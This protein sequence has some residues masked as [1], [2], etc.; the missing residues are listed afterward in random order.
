MHVLSDSSAAWLADG[1]VDAVIDHKKGPVGEQA[2]LRLLGSA[3]FCTPL[4]PVKSIVLL[5]IQRENLP[6]RSVSP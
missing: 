2:V 4:L 3:A 6:T 1:L 5:V